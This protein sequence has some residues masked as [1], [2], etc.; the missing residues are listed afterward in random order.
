M[1]RN[2]RTRLLLRRIR[3]T[4]DERERERLA[5]EVVL[6]HEAGARYLVR[7]FCF[8]PDEDDIAEARI[9]MHKAAL[10]CRPELGS[11]YMSVCS[12]FVMRYVASRRTGLGIHVPTSVGAKISRLRKVMIDTHA[13]CMTLEEQMQL[14]DVGNI[15][16]ETV[17]MLLM[18]VG[19]PSSSGDHVSVVA[20]RMGVR[21]RSESMEDDDEVYG[22]YHDPVVPEHEG[23]MDADRATVRTFLAHLTPMERDAVLAFFDD[24]IDTRAVAAKHGVSRE[25]LRKARKAGMQR[26]RAMINPDEEDQDGQEEEDQ[27]G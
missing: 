3:D 6:M 19:R 23:E 22:N 15:I 16:P 27:G 25:T 11:G 26:M 10:W 20:N 21:S 7:K 18:S 24:S 9:A 4:S 12:W 2:E 1:N 14:A 8:E 17:E 5:W 13:A